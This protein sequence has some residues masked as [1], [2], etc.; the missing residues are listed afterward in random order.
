MHIYVFEVL[1]NYCGGVAYNI[2]VDLCEL[3]GLMCS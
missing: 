3:A 1:Y 2:Q